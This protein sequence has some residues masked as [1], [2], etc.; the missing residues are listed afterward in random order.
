MQFILSLNNNTI[1]EI[2][3][4]LP[5]NIKH[6]GCILQ[7]MYNTVTNGLKTLL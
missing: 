2:Y 7:I 3:I 6:N 5:E 4:Y 1:Y